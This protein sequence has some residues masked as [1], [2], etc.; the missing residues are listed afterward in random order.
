MSTYKKATGKGSFSFESVPAPIIRRME[1]PGAENTKKGD[2]ST[3]SAVTLSTKAPLLSSHAL[4]ATDKDTP[5]VSST[6][7]LAALDGLKGAASFVVMAFHALMYWGSILDLQEG[8]K[9]SGMSNNC[10][11]K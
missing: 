5:Q 2:P 11:R 8:Y 1:R 4:Q 10:G 7:D 3:K 6:Y 9:V